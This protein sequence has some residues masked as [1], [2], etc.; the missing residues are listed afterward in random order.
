M[1]AE[2]FFTIIQKEIL[3]SKE[4]LNVQSIKEKITSI[5][6]DI[7]DFQKK[8]EKLPGEINSE[9]TVII[10]DLKARRSNLEE[11]IKNIKETTDSAYQDVQV[12]VQMAW[13]D[14]RSAYDSAK[15]RFKKES[16]I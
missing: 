8:A 15:E 13:E 10:N 11:K 4:N 14:L 7:D 1:D 2:K 9:V 12:G 3:M 5:N 6:H 16:L